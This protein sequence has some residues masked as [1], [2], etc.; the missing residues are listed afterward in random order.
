MSAAPWDRIVSVEEIDES[1]VSA[2][3]CGNEA[4]DNWFLGKALN[5]CYLGFCQ[6][7]IA[8]D[9]EGIAGFFSLS[10]TQIEPRSLTNS[11]RAGKNALAHPGLLL[12]RIAVRT[13]LQGSPLH[14]GTLLLEHAI[15]RA[16]EISKTVGGRFIVL[17][18]KD[19]GLCAWYA[20]HGFRSLR[21]SRLRMVLPMK[22]A[23]ALISELGEGHF[24]F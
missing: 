6:V 16:F 10:P 4:M 9:D 5:W 22:D 17:D 21:D 1:L 23:R 20:R 18:A 15:C 11:M 24:V 12:G 13:D 19:D 3:S 14:V 7:Y 8:L 2:F